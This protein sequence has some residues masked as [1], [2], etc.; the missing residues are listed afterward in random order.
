MFMMTT[1]T[2]TMTKAEVRTLIEAKLVEFHMNAGVIKQAK[3]RKRPRQGYTVGFRSQRGDG[4]RYVK[5]R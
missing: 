2:N 4:P 1:R 5:E 3:P